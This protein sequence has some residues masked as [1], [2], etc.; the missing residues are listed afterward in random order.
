MLLDFKKL[1]ISSPE[2]QL[3]RHFHLKYLI[4]PHTSKAK[5]P[6]TDKNMMYWTRNKWYIVSR[7]HT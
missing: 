3:H 2:L 5:L 7:V 4:M 6:K 1:I